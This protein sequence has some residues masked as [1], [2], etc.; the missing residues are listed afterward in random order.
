MIAKAGL[1]ALLIML[2][3]TLAHPLPAELAASTAEISADTAAAARSYCA[4]AKHSIL[5][6]HDRRILCF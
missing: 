3:S 5:L 2:S 4:N 6:S 1:V